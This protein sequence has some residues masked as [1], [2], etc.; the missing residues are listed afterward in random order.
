MTFDP[1]GLTVYVDG[2]YVSGDEARPTVEIRPYAAVG[3]GFYNLDVQSHFI[4][5]GLPAVASDSNTYSGFNVGGGILL[6]LR[7]EWAIGPDVR[8]HHVFASGNDFHFLATT[9]RFAFFF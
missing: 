7:E 6:R 3:F 1:T 5:N 8:Y 4:L 2:E 9:L